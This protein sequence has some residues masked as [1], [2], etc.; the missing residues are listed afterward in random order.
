MYRTIFTPTASNNTVP[1]I[2]PSEWYG[3]EIEFI[4]FPIEHRSAE[5]KKN[6][7]AG[8]MKYFGAWKT[9]KSAKEIIADIH[10]NRTSGKT[11]ILEDF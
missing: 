1:F 2:V 8:I 9:D 11:R 10:N 5:N 6:G 7:K 3:K 4:A